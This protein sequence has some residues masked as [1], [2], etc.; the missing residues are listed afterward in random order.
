VSE[1]ISGALRRDILCSLLEGWVN[2]VVVAK[3]GKTHKWVSIWIKAIPEVI[4]DLMILSV[5]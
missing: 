1:C 4:I 2:D 3:C 5:S